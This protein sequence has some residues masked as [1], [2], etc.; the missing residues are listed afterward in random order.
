MA[1]PS[2]VKYR[3]DRD[4]WV[5]TIRG[6]YVTLARGK[7]NRRQAM[8]EFH[9]LKASEGKPRLPAPASVSVGEHEI[10]L[11]IGGSWTL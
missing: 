1:R 7:R 11:I 10:V 2:T 4:A 6:K 5:T 3:Q 8:D 9:R